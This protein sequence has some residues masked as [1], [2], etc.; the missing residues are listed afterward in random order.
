MW[1][2]GVAAWRFVSCRTLLNCIRC[3][4]CIPS[5]LQMPLVQDINSDNASPQLEIVVAMLITMMCYRGIAAQLRW[6]A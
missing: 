2:A 1:D 3:I 5:P 6:G 4:R